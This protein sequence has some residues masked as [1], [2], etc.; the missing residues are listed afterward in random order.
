MI[1]LT[2]FFG[3]QTPFLREKRPL[4]FI[5]PRKRPFPRFKRAQKNLPC[6]GRSVCKDPSGPV[7]R[8]LSPRAKRGSTTIY[9]RPPSPTGSSVIHG[10]LPDGQPTW[11]R[12]KL[13]SDGVYMARTV[14]DPSVSSYLA[15]PSLLPFRGR[16]I[17]VALSLKSPSP[18]VIRRP[19]LRCP[20]FP[21]RAFGTPR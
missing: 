6:G 3:G 12:P 5:S 17:S 16:S 19:A 4:L 11:K 7:S 13:A 15:F 14:T 21:H 1:F 18:D 8:V 9:L 10:S 2:H 20:D